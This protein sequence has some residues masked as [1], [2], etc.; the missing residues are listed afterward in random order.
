MKT[1]KF[2]IKYFLSLFLT[3]SFLSLQ[4]Q[5]ECG[6]DEFLQIQIRNNPGLKIQMEKMEEELQRMTRLEEQNPSRS[7]VLTIPVV[8]H[9]I[10]NTDQQNISEAQIK[11]QMDVL[12]EDFRMLNSDIS[13]I[14]EDFS[15]LAGDSQIEFQLANIAPDGSSTN[16]IVRYHTDRT[17]FSRYENDMNIKEHGYWDRDYYLNVWV[18]NISGGLLGRSNFPGTGTP[19]EDGIIMGYQ[20][21]GRS[22]ENPFSGAYN[23]GRTLTHEIGHWFNLRHIWERAGCDNDDGVSDTPKQDN[24][25]GGR[26]SHPQ[27][28]CGS[29]DM[30]MNYMDYVYDD[31]M[32]MFSK[33]QIARMHAAIK[34]HRPKLG[35]TPGYCPEILAINEAPFDE[36]DSITYGASQYIVSNT[37]FSQ[38]KIQMQAG[39]YVLLQPGFEA[40]GNVEFIASIGAC[41]SIEAT[42]SQAPQRT[43]ENPIV[44]E[45]IGRDDIQTMSMKAYP[46]PFR[47]QMTIDYQ[48]TKDEAIKL[49]VRNTLG[50][51]V[52]VLH[53]GQ[54]SV[55]QHRTQLQAGNLAAGVYY[56]TLETPQERK[57]EKIVVAGSGGM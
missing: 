26:P 49:Y 48:L 31:A 40:N 45:E 38:A 25:Y 29:S 55:G 12:N 53:Q 47:E 10:Y 16:G 9:I 15:D 43:I 20:Y 2:F 8:F 14:P 37:V 36:L 4:A 51:I 35:Q 44:E 28:S 5:R 52:K 34:L 54:Q 57:V 21:I 22:P 3:L 32:F 41:S 33:G 13:D 56:L 27:T 6:T 24:Y 39:E 42:M 18:C 7:G 50:Q 11:S 30:F 19:E 1:N 23:L 46:N 17:S